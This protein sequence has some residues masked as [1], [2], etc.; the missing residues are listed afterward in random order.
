MT[1]RLGENDRARSGEWIDSGQPPQKFTFI[2]PPDIRLLKREWLVSKTLPLKGLGVLFG[3][4]GCG[5]SFL[6][7]DIAMSVATG[8]EFLGKPTRKAGVIY[9]AA[10]D[11]D[12][13]QARILAWLQHNEFPGDEAIIAVV[14]EAPDLWQSDGAE[15]ETLIDSILAENDVMKE[16]GAACGLVIFD[17]MRDVLPGMNE[18]GSDEMG[19]AM[20]LFRKVAQAL[21]ALVLI[22]HHV[23]KYGDGEDPR[24]SGALIGAAD[25]ALGARVDEIDENFVRSLW[26]RKQRN[27]PDAR[28]DK[29]LRW[30]YSLDTVQ[31]P[32]MAEDGDVETSCVIKF[33]GAPVPK[34]AMER[35]L[36]DAAIIVQRAL[37]QLISEGH[38]KHPPMTCQCP[39]GQMAIEVDSVRE[40]ARS[41]GICDPSS[42]D[43]MQ[44]SKKAFQRGK[45]QLIAKN[46]AFE[47]EGWMWPSK[48]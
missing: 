32:V 17:T 8:Q 42:T 3:P 23:P 30:V 15:A 38:G 10:E 43:P 5:K 21:S 27:G 36:S 16:K 24:G 28:G 14:P 37:V 26:M 35:K 47:R 19:L 2:Y 48:F 1:D 9:V 22:I 40:R 13:V 45:Q 20:R 33:S 31:L 12:G 18:N 44:A 25:V 39:T 4:S 11:A 29:S 46:R 41:L 6:A 34:R 7:T